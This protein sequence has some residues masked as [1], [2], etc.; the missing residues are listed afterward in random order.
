[1]PNSLRLVASTAFGAVVGL[2]LCQPTRAEFDRYQTNDLRN[3]AFESQSADLNWGFDLGNSMGQ[4]ASSSISSNANSSI[5]SS[6]AQGDMS[7]SSLPA[8]RN[9]NIT[10]SSP[11][12]LNQTYNGNL[13]NGSVNLAP[14]PSASFSFGFSQS[15]AAAGSAGGFL[16]PTATSSCDFNTVDP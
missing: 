7:H 16:P 3:P 1:M 2:I 4:S 10:S 15:A 9:A 13:A 8:Q 12:T 14:V 11:P 5:G 6:G